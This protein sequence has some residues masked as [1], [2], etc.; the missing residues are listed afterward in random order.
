MRSAAITLGLSLG[1]LLLSAMPTHART[2]GPFQAQIVDEETGQPIAGVVVVALYTRKVPA[3][4]HPESHF[5]D[6]DET[7]SDADGRF[8]LPARQLPI[9]TPLSHVVGP[10]PIIF[11]AGYKGWHFKG[12]PSG[13]HI[14]SAEREARHE[15]GWRQFGTV[16]VVIEM[17]RATTKEQRIF[18]SDRAYE[19]P[20]IPDNRAPLL[21]KALED[22]AIAIRNLR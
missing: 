2:E 4:I 1:T 15:E 5:Y 9:S 12:V 17:Q 7:V 10:Q 20:P 6:L 8:T 13:R 16:G 21:K 14:D 22:E 11:K 18:A 3:G 19:F